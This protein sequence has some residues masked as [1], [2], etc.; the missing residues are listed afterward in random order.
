[1]GPSLAKSIS[2]KV[3]LCSRCPCSGGGEASQEGMPAMPRAWHLEPLG[4]CRLHEPSHPGR[5]WGREKRD[6]AIVLRVG[7]D[8]TDAQGRTAYLA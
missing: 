6:A 1:M 5:A 7:E 8:E 4:F 3:E 2:A